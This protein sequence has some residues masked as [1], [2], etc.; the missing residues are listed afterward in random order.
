MKNFFEMLGAFLHAA[1]VLALVAAAFVC[2][3]YLTGTIYILFRL[4][5]KAA[6]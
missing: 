1:F 4:G 2:A 3:G 5:F 6:L